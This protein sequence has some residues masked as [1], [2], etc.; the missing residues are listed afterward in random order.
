MTEAEA[1]VAEH[2]PFHGHGS[3]ADRLRSVVSL[4]RGSR[5]IASAAAQVVTGR[6][7]L[8]AH[9]NLRPARWLVLRIALVK[10]ECSAPTPWMH[11]QPMRLVRS[12]AA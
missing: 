4:L 2:P 6:V 12:A 1:I 9:I 10:P 8:S 7:V 11:W 3:I 5:T